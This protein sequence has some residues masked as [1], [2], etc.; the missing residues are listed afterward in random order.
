MTVLR[1]PL[2]L[3]GVCLLPLTA[4]A[5]DVPPSLRTAAACAPVGVP[6][7]PRAPRIVALPPADETHFDKTL[8][9]AGERVGIDHGTEGGIV[10]GGRY[11]VRR[12]M[13]FFGAPRAQHTIGW[14]RVTEAS[15]SSATAEIEFSCD[16]IAV[17]DVIEPAAELTLPDGIARTFVGG[18]LDGQQ[19]MRV[20][21]GS[22]GRA[23]QGDRDFVLADGGQNRGLTAGDRY[24]AFARVAAAESPTV[25]EAVV[26]AVFPEQSLLRITAASEAVFAGDR[27][28]R[29]MGAVD[30]GI[31]GADRSATAAAP[32]NAAAG[33]AVSGAPTA[34]RSAAADITGSPASERRVTF[35]DVYFTLDRHTLRPE[36]TRLLDEA[37][38]T[39]QADPTLRVQVEGH[40][41]SIGTAEYNLTLGQRRA[42]AVRAYLLEKG[43]AASRL[44]TVS[45]GEERPAHDNGTTEGRRLNRRAVLSVSIQR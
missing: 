1:L 10:G 44:T 6:V 13:R 4:A 3:L 30:P 45:Y 28:V 23:V 39:L 41:C 8:Y 38:S 7:S 34:A 36:A 18:T 14:L 29:R 5:Q 26:V 16:A 32:A 24:A 11:V 40:T 9:T 21:Y 43:I 22:D 15:T 31:A 25:A 42:A 37:V 27:L 35:E 20:S 33:A 17:G 2:T 19:T 12:P